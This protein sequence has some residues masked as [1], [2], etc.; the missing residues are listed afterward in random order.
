ML[1]FVWLFPF[2]ARGNKFSVCL[3][4]SDTLVQQMALRVCAFQGDFFVV[5]FFNNSY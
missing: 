1:L 3:C 5:F 4:L 2:S